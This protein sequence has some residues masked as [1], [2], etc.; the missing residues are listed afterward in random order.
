MK[1]MHLLLASIAIAMTPI[2]AR[3]ELQRRWPSHGSLRD[4]TRMTIGAMNSK[5]SKHPSGSQSSIRKFPLESRA[6][7]PAH[8]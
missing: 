8:S 5:K 3:E 4:R 6:E 2:V 1:T 7:E